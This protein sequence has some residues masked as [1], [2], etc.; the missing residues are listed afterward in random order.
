MR[1]LH[2]TADWKWTGP[3]EPMLHAVTGL[4]ARGHE[5]DLVCPSGPPGAG[6][7]LLEKAHERGV[8]PPL[9]LSRERGVRLYRDLGEVRRLRELV[10][11]AGY[12]LVHVHHTRDHLLARRA[13]GARGRRA[14][15]LVASWHQGEPIPLHPGNRWLFGPRA[16]DGLCVLGD[17]IAERAR[18]TLGFEEQ[19]VAVL[20]GVVDLERFRPHA[21]DP[22]LYREFGLEPGQRIVGVVARLQP[23]RRFDLLL[24]AFRR[25]L[26]EAPELRLLVIGRGTRAQQVLHAPVE[27]LGLGAAVV[28]AGYLGA[29]FPN[30]LALLDTLV[31]LVPGSDGS[32]R[33]VLEAMATGIPV[34]ASRRGLLPE[35]VRDGTSG[36][37]I[38]EDPEVLAETLIDVA[39]RPADWIVRGKAARETARG[40]Y[41]LPLH[42]GR[43]ERFYTSL[44]AETN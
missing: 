9:L 22:A 30:V 33:A 42:A 6:G 43:L 41:A 23:H 7:G 4:R 15:A 32:C 25:A 16:S 36:A 31:F 12:Q 8:M 1:L 17:A 13:L 28:A 11:E 21:P 29:S 18:E 3:A 38:D 2:L 44:L 27:R 20:P 26:R 5:V 35:I 10:R 37:L 24:E 14:A 40:R 19:R 34:I 39:R